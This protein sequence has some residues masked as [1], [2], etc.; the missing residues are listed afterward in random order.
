MVGRLGW[1]VADQAVSSLGNFALGLYAARTFGAASFGAFSLAFV[2]YTVVLNAS[3]GI[4]TDPLLVR[5]SGSEGDTWRRSAASA[6]GTALVVGAAGAALSILVGLVMPDPVGS[7]F[8]A[9]GVGLPG[10]MLQDSWRFCFFAGRRSSSA[11]LNDVV[12]GLLLVGVLAAMDHTGA[13]SMFRCLIAFGLTALAS[14]VFGVA[15]ARVVPRPLR[16]AAW[17]R[18]HRQLAGRYLI[19]NVS[20]S[21]ASQI[22]SSVL[23]AVAGLAPV[24]YVRSAEMLMGPFAVVLMGVSQ[25]AVPEASRVFHRTPRRL[26]QFCLAVGGVQA[27]AA[28]AWGAVLLLVL[29]H[30]LGELMLGRLWGTASTLLPA[31]VLNVIAVCFSSAIL[32]GLRAMG[33]S[34]RSLRAQLT[35]SAAYVVGG[36]V[37]AFA[38]GALGTCWGVAL[39]NMAAAGLWW[40][41]LRAALADHGRS[42]LAAAPDAEH[43]VPAPEPAPGGVG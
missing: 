11:F 21:G 23:G 32:S 30:G 38:D 10:L 4:A 13:R 41:H 8:V 1:G 24:G 5:H 29:P 35:A 17:L 7:A 33:V 9:L 27:V 19:E 2:T 12:W 28:F 37:G 39:A 34:W 20:A 31:V 40:Y 3:R 15:Q 18:E 43:A 14:A 25:V 16:A 42:A 22:R 26:G 36:T 6:S